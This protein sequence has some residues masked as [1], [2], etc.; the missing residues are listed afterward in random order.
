MKQMFI[1]FLV[2]AVL[3]VGLLSGIPSVQHFVVILAWGFNLMCWAVVLAGKMKAPDYAKVRK[4]AVWTTLT[5]ALWVSVV[6]ISGNPVLGASI[7]LFRA[8][9]LVMAYD[10]TKEAKTV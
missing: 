3:S 2:Y 8:S 9:I 1:G 5:T 6:V 10:K 7:V 4:N